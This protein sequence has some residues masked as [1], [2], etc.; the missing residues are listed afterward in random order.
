M[1]HR[2]LHNLCL[3]KV[4]NVQIEFVEILPYTL[5]FMT[6]FSGKKQTIYSFFVIPHNQCVVTFGGSFRLQARAIILHMRRG[7]TIHQMT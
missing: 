2:H 5:S 4:S 7:V 6:M 3:P 1:L